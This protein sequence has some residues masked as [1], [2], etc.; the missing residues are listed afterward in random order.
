MAGPGP[1]TMDN[2]RWTN[3]LALDLSYGAQVPD[4]TPVYGPVVE[5]GEKGVC[6]LTLTCSAISANTLD[7]TIE[8]SVNGYDGWRTSQGGAGAGTGAFTQIAAPGA[9]SLQFLVDRFVR[10]KYDN[11]VNSSTSTVIGEAV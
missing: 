6:R 9:E 8:T 5:V 7:V 1:Y 11:G 4:T 10:A 2:G 3:A